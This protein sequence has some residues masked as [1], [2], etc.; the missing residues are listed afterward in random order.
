MFLIKEQVS[1]TIS[2]K[3]IHK[4]EKY[5]KLV[6]ICQS[7]AHTSIKFILLYNKSAG[8]LYR[9]K[10]HNWANSQIQFKFGFGCSY[11]YIQFFLLLTSLIFTSFLNLYYI[12]IQWNNSEYVPH[13]PELFMKC[14]FLPLQICIFMGSL[15]K[16]SSECH[17][18][19]EVFSDNTKGQTN[20]MFR[21]VGS[22]LFLSK[23][24]VLQN[25][26]I[27]NIKNYYYSHSYQLSSIIWKW[28]TSTPSKTIPY[29]FAVNC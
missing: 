9:Q 11:F 7:H 8:S 28:N 26:L 29:F 5:R 22:Q 1:I 18:N 27:S 2:M 15:L 23:S 13:F 16:Q 3:S 17:V 25:G 10:I 6:G 20:L 12:K 21:T 24:Y 14:T 19:V 4:S